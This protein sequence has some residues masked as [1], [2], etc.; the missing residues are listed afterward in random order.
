M[1]GCELEYT[2][3]ATSVILMYSP[4]TYSWT[5]LLI[6]DTSYLVGNMSN[7]KIAEMKALEPLKS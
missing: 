3:S 5:G 1:R 6:W 4:V 7:S 2:C